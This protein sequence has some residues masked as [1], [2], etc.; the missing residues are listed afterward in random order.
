M[1]L[2]IYKDAATKY[3]VEDL[4]GALIPGSRL[5][6]I[7]KELESG[8]SISNFTQEFLR[9]KGLFALL[10]YARNEI[11]FNEFLRAAQPEQSARRMIAEERALKEQAEHNMQKEAL[12]A[13]MKLT[14]ERMAAEKRAFDS[15]PKNIARAKQF[16]LREKYNLSLFID[17]EDF[18]KLIDILRN[19]DK[20]IRMTEDELIWLLKNGNKNFKTYFT[21]ELREGYHKNEAHF[22]ESEFEKEKNP[23]SAVNAS[24]HYRKCNKATKAVSLLSTIK[25]EGIK[26]RRLKSAIYTTHGG[27]KKDLEEWDEA[28]SFGE[29][30]HLMNPKSFHPCT[31]LGAV[32]IQTGRV[33][34]GLDW[35]RKAVELGYDKESMDDELRGIFSHLEI[36][37]QRELRD[38]LL[39]IDYERYDWAT[40]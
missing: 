22:F 13:R 38:H 37:K 23:W 32:N 39:K 1:Q 15:D 17:K 33:E 24:K 25:V 6:N 35:Y 11:N 4:A 12:L 14:Q 10:N 20:G 2:N 18:P 29:Q 16:K 26:D 30:A 28:L 21:K 7:L 3:H 36:S 5:S 31:L 8:R 27:A 19:I 40:D 34:I 9:N